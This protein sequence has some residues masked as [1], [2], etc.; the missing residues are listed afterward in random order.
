MSNL[1]VWQ[2]LARPPKDALKQ[3]KGGRISGAT[4]IDPQWRYKIMTEI[5]GICG[6]GWKYTVDNQRL[7]NGAN[8][9]VFAFVDV[10]VYVNVD[11]KWSEPIPASGGSKLIAK[12]KSGMYNNDEAFKMATTDALGTAMKMLGVAAD[13]YMGKFDG[14][15]YK[16]EQR[17]VYPQP[18]QPP[19]QRAWTIEQK[20]AIVSAGHAENVHQAKAMLDMSVLP[21]G[22][23]AVHCS[24]WASYYRAKRNDGLTEIDASKHAN[25]VYLEK[26]KG[27]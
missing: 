13:I 12:E 14:S 26:V 11:G 20:E 7:E 9:E 24:S 2:S 6:V 15:K 22:A 21:V 5:F 4:N 8:D 10:S 3:I 17:E 18:P 1:D 16:D 25:G 27:K 19:H 23:P